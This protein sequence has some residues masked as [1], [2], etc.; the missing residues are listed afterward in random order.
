[1]LTISNIKDIKH[2]YIYI[3]I[4]M[5]IYLSLYLDFCFNYVHIRLL[6]GKK[7]H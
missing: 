1:M 5:K 4:Y 2:I 6:C 3:Y 7:L